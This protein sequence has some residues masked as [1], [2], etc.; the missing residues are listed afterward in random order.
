MTRQSWILPA[1]LAL[2]FTGTALAASDE[3]VV[4]LDLS[5]SN[6]SLEEFLD[7]EIRTS[8]PEELRKWHL[9]DDG[10]LNILVDAQTQA[11]MVDDQVRLQ[12]GETIFFEIRV[13]DVWALPEAELRSLVEEVREYL[14]ERGPELIPQLERILSRQQKAADTNI[15]AYIAARREDRA[16]FRAVQR[17]VQTVKQTVQAVAKRQEKEKAELPGLRSS[18]RYVLMGVLGFLLMLGLLLL[19]QRREVWVGFGAR[20]RRVGVSDRRAFARLFNPSGVH[21]TL[22]HEE[23]REEASPGPVSGLKTVNISEGGIC[24]FLHHEYSPNSVIEL[25]VELDGEQRSLMFRGYVVW[26]EKVPVGDGTQTFLTGVR[27]GEATAEDFHI[28]K[29]YVKTRLPGQKRMDSLP[30]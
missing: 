14:S 11:L 18:A 19:W 22:L 9:I 24:L 27:L 23:H 2:L 29:E 28:L 13:Q 10:G 30:A 3:R 15:G 4:S 26:Q 1:V 20:L 6:P 12:P 5:V 8:L 7:A 16:T 17:D 25:R 21:C